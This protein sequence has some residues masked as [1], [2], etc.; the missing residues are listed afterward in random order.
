MT[1]RKRE[2]RHRMVCA[3]PTRTS[4]ADCDQLLPLGP[5][6]DS[7]ERVRLEIRAAE[8]AVEV[9]EMTELWLYVGDNVS[10]DESRGYCRAES[11]AAEHSAEWHAGELARCIATHDED[12]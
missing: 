8:I 4:C 10:D 6:N 7:D 3:G 2:C 11:N 12:Q 9:E 5:S 1:E